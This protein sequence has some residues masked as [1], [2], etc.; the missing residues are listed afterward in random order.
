MGVKTTISG[1][2]IL[3]LL[4]ICELLFRENILPALDL[5]VKVLKIFY[6]LNRTSPFSRPKI[7]FSTRESLRRGKKN[8]GSALDVLQ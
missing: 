6:L 5:G 1:A 3:N 2:E 7:F 4:I 8:K